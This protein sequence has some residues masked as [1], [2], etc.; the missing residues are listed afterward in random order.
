[1]VKAIGT[2]AAAMDCRVDIVKITRCSNTGVTLH[3]K[4]E[5]LRKYFSQVYGTLQSPLVHFFG[6]INKRA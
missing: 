1:M 5:V 3:C 2:I 6:N 4:S